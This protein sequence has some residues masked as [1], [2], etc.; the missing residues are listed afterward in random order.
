[1]MIEITQE[2][3]NSL[4]EDS[5]FLECLNALGVDNWEGYDI[6]CRMERGEFSEDDI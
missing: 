1:M 4:K 6:A 5:M 2:E 3:Y